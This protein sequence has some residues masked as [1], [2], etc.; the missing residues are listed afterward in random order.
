MLATPSIRVALRA[1]DV[2]T[3]VLV[4]LLDAAMIELAQAQTSEEAA[5]LGI[6]PYDV[7]AFFAELHKRTDLS[8]LEVARREYQ[9]L[10]ILD[11]ADARG[12]TIHEFLAEDP[13]FFVDILCDVFLPAHRDGSQDAQLSPERQTRAELGYRLLKGMHMLPGKRVGGE[14]AEETI[15]EWIDEVRRKAVEQDRAVVADQFIG[16]LLAHAPEDLVD[17]GWPERAVRNVIEKLASDDVDDGVAMERN[18]MRG[19][20]TRAIYAGGDLERVLASQYRGYADIVRA[21]WPR[22]AW[23]LETIGTPL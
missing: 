6:T 15:L 17:H 21:Q 19:V 8:P 4:R 13:G 1:S 14:V 2:P 20:T 9:A 12:L 16:Q 3:D 7:V 18:N 22:V 10:P 5:R 11:L 23:L